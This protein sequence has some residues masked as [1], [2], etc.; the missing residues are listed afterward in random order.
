MTLFVFVKSKTTKHMFC[1]RNDKSLRNGVNGP[2]WTFCNGCSKNDLK[3]L[4][5]RIALI[6]VDKSII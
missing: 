6:S 4:P 3:R 2:F 1:S 5:L